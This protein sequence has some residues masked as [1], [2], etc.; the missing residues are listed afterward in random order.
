MPHRGA[1]ILAGV[2]RRVIT[3]AAVSGAVCSLAAA[4]ATAGSTPTSA[5]S[6]AALIGRLAVL[7][8]PQTPADVLPAGVTL[9]AL[10]Q[11]TVI[12]SLTRLVATP[13][14]ASVYLVVF[15]PARGSLPLWRASLGDQ[16]SLVSVT[17]ARAALTE[18]VPAVD[19]SNGNS[20]AIIGPSSRSPNPLAPDYYVG[21]VPN[22]VA[23]VA[24][25]FANFQRKHRY[26]VNAQAASNVVVAPFDSGAPFLLRATWYAADGALIPTSDSAA[27]HAI[28][29]NQ[30]IQKKRIIRQ[31]ARIRYRPPSALL[32][33]FAVFSVT[34]R[35][36]VKVGGL[37]ISHP[38]L[39]SLPLAILRITA[40]EGNPRFRPEFDPMDIRQATTRSGVSAWIIPGVH[41]LCVA[42]VDKPHFPFGGTGAGMACSRDVASAVADGAGL[43]SGYP[44]GVTWHYGVLPN[45]KLTLTIRTGPHSHKTIHPPDGVYIYRTAH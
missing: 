32:T 30:N 31:D 5:G 29:A 10:G 3:A 21:I 16:V 23:R 37:T 1:G 44:G 20:V 11:G 7:Q 13:A 18:P 36:G 26:V 38:A 41:S 34:S 27:L 25:T 12:P 24:W 42:E 6:A 35:N 33:A 19:L 17:A 8:R 2:F 45:T 22:G 43:S 9:P 15:T 28:A 39:S 14:G 4:V 40:R